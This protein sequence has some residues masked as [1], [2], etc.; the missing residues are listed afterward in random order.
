MDVRG[1]EHFQAVEAEG[2]FLFA[3]WHGR[4]VAAMPSHAHRDYQ[5]LVS[6]SAD[7]GLVTDLLGSF[8]YGVVRGSSSRGGARAVRELQTHLKTERPVAVTPDGPRG[9]MHGINPGLCWLARES[10]RAI[11]PVGVACDRAWHLK[12][13][14]RFTIPKPRARVVVTYGAPLRLG[15]NATE[16]ELEAASSALASSLHA[17]ESRGFEHLGVERDW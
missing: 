8:G 4:M 10:G 3:L 12:S 16:K 17:A 2:G 1:A 7:G 9:P 11:L 5:V 15:P 6:P 13:W 14:D